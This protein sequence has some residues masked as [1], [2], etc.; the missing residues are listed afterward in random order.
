VA[1]VSTRIGRYITWVSI[2]LLCV[3][4]I[5]LTRELASSRDETSR[6]REAL[7]TQQDI[8]DRNRETLRE[9]CRTNGIMT[10]IVAEDADIRRQMLANGTVPKTLVE[11]WKIG[12]LIYNGFLDQ[13]T[14]Q[15]ACEQIVRP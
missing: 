5:Y 10:A 7:Q 3:A 13:L 4:L 15:P 1:A 6:V 9:L 11:R 14:E 8:S 2:I 12:I